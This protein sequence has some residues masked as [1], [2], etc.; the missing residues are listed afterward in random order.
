MLGLLFAAQP[1]LDF[2]TPSQDTAGCAAADV[3][4]K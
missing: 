3:A 4:A 1:P 2:S